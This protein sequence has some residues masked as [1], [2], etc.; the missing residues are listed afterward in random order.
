MQKLTIETENDN[1]IGCFAH[2]Y[3]KQLNMM[4]LMNPTLKAWTTDRAWPSSTFYLFTQN[5][6]IYNQSFPSPRFAAYYGY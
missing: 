3:R 6:G 1:V 2:A 4:Y 5:R